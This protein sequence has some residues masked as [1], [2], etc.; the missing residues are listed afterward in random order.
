MTLVGQIGTTKIKQSGYNPDLPETGATVWTG[1]PSIYSYPPVATQMF[2]SSTNSEDGDGAKTGAILTEVHGLNSAWAL[3]SAFAIMDGLNPVPTSEYFNRVYLIHVHSA[4]SAGKNIGEICC[5]AGSVSNG[6][7]NSMYAHIGSGDSK[8]LVGFVTIPMSS[9]GLLHEVQYTV[10]QDK[11]IECSLLFRRYG[12]I[13]QLEDRVKVYRGTVTR[14]WHDDPL[15]LPARTDI[16][17]RGKK[18]TAG[19]TIAMTAGLDLVIK[20]QK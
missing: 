16:E 10:G 15:E 7:P 13:F 12:N 3:C 11:D 1:T 8:G 17:V 18:D 20:P 19:G 5:G 4:G 2:V 6:I 14:N 9:V